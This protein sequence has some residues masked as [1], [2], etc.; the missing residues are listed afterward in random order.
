MENARLFAEL[1]GR[2]RELEAASRAKSV[3]LSRMSHELHT[4]LNAII[5][6]TEIMEMDP[7][8]TRGAHRLK[9][10][11]GDW[12]IFAVGAETR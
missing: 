2:T 9:G 8:T 10:L 5:G 1:E 7:A 3:F 4:P 6:F 11:P 12:Q